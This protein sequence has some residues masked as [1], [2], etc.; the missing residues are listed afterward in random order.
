MTT[1]STKS[2]LSLAA[3][4]VALSMAAA[5]PVQA[6]GGSTITSPM[7]KFMQRNAA[8]THTNTRQQAAKQT[9]AD[10]SVFSDARTGAAQVYDL[11]PS[12][13]GIV[14]RKWLRD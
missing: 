4:A 14:R 5:T 12:G 2:L 13:T 9:A 3:A 7:V 1:T 6:R 11:E 10:R 8:K